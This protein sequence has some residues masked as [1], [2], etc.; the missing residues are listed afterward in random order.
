MKIKSRP[1]DASMLAATDWVAQLRD[2]DVPPDPAGDGGHSFPAT[3]GPSANGHVNR[4]VMGSVNSPVNRPV[5]GSVNRR[6]SVNGRSGSTPAGARVEITERAAIGDK[7]RM[8]IAWCEMISCIS[9]HADPAALGE[10]DI[11]ARAIAA[12][13]CVDAVGR[14]TCPECQQNGSGFWAPRPVVPW[15]RNTAVTMAGLMAAALRTEGLA[16]KMVGGNTHEP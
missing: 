6:P 13:W 1:N 7:L 4:P 2:D 9:H 11:R 15:D 16:D 12:G 3:A 8:P 5:R 10:A 14:L